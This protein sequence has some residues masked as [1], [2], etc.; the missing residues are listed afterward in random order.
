MGF[1]TD[2]RDA[3]TDV[4]GTE[5]AWTVLEYA[6]GVDDAQLLLEALDLQQVTWGWSHAR[7]AWLA[8]SRGRHGRVLNANILRD[9]LPER[10]AGRAAGA[11][12]ALVTTGLAVPTGEFV[13]AAHVAAR[14][15]P[16]RCYKL[17]AAGEALAAETAAPG[18][19]PYLLHL[20]TMEVRPPKVA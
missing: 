10:E 4:N 7:T 6:T 15:R 13:Q 12:K 9:A 19:E 2:V 18:S 11:L 8:L 17:T 16:V 5:A 20:N 14:G 3:D 1:I